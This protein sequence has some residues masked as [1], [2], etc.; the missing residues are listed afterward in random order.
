MLN[1]NSELSNNVDV[2]M[3]G[4]F[5]VFDNAQWKKKDILSNVFSIYLQRYDYQ[6]ALEKDKSV[7]G[8]A[9]LKKAQKLFGHSKN[10]DDPRDKIA[11]RNYEDISAYFEKQPVEFYENVQW[12]C[13]EEKFLDFLCDV[14][15]KI[16]EA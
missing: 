9:V 3:E 1:N 10:E 5:S 14:Y 11:V 13:E 2:I 12:P 7:S 8:K 16:H 15:D 6:E 4:M